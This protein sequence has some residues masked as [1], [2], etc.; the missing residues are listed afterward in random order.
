MDKM[1]QKGVLVFSYTATSEQDL[2]AVR[3]RYANAVFEGF[4]P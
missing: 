4:K 1:N 3:E 2:Q